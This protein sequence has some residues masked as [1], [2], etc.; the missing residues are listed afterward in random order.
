MHYKTQN[1]IVTLSIVALFLI[2]LF[3]F[4]SNKGSE[5]L[6]L[7]KRISNL[8]TEVVNLQKQNE[9]L[10]IEID[11]LNNDQQYVEDIARRDYGLL[12]KN[13]IVFDFNKEGS[14]KKK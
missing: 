4:S 3:F 2:L 6:K 14:E 7:R 11:K 13:E 8:S 10:K 5:Y 9:E 12:K 1:R